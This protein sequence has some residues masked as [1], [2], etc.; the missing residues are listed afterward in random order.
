MAIHLGRRSPDGSCGR[1]EGW[2]AHL[3]PANRGCTLLLG[4]AP[5]RVCRVSLRP[6]RHVAGSDGIVTVALVLA[7]RR[8][9]VT[10]YPALRS[11]DFPRAAS[12]PRSSA[13]RGHPA[14]S[15][16][17]SILPAWRPNDDRRRSARQGPVDRRVAHRVGGEVLGPPDVPGGPSVERP[18][19]PQRFRVEW[20]ELR[21]LDPPAPVELLDDEHGIE[22]QAHLPGAQLPGK[23]ERPD[24][25]GVFGDVVRLDAEVVRDRCVRRCGRIERVRAGE[26]DQDCPG[27]GLAGVRARGAVRPDDEPWGRRR[28]PLESGPERVVQPFGSEGSTGSS[29]PADEPGLRPRSFRQAHWSGS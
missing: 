24:D 13:T 29:T 18:Q 19:D 27:R 4:L 2:A 3:S 1:P 26:V 7:S 22:E 10:R 6:H 14:V 25:R 16:A 28:R 21:V 20:L 23:L 11:S 12:R 9:G 5:G 8:T 15:L 17:A